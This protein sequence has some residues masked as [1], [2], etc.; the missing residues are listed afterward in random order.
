MLLIPFFGRAQQFKFQFNQTPVSSALVEVAGK[1]NNR[2]SFDA[3]NLEQFTVDGSLETDSIS[4]VFTWLLNGTGYRAELK[5]NT[6]LI[7][8][9]GENGV[10]SMPL[11]I[12]VSGYISDS[13]SGERLP[14]ATVLVGQK[15]AVIPSTVDGVFSVK[16]Q[17]NSAYFFQVRYLGYQTLDTV[18]TV[19]PENKVFNFA[20]QQKLQNIATIDVQGHKLEMLEVSNDAG[21]VTFNPRRFADLPNFGETDV[22]KTLQ[23]LPGISTQENSSQLNI[24]GS[25]ADQNLVTFDGFTLYNLDHFFGV[26]SALNPNVIKDI[27][28]Y[29]GGFDSRYG[30]RVSGIVE[31][32]GKSGDKTKPRVY[33]GVNLISANLTTEIPISEKL[34]LVAAGRRAYSDVYSSWLADAILAKQT[35][36]ASRFPDADEAIE[37]E[38][39]FSDF[40]T[41]LTWTPSKKDIVSFSA[42]GAK[43]NLNSSNVLEKDFIEIDTKDINK[44]GNYGFGISWKTQHKPNYVSELQLGHSGYYNDYYNNTTL[45]DSVDVQIPVNDRREYQATNEENKLIDYF[46]SYKST[47]FLNT[48]NQLEFGVASRY[49]TFNYYK[50]ADDDVVYSKLEKSAT[51]Y[52]GFIQDKIAVGEKWFVKPGFRINYYDEK[53][54]F[55]F[56]PRFAVHYMANENVLLKMAAGKYYQFLNKIAT[57]QTYGYNRDFW[58]LAEGDR[59]PVVSSEHL[60]L[61]TSITAGKFFFDVEG[62]YKNVSGLQEYLFSEPDRTPGET[63]SVEPGEEPLSLFIAGD[64][65]AYGIDF[66]AKYQITNFSSWLAY[67]LSKSTRNFDEINNGADVPALYD[68]RHEL[69]WTNMFSHKRWNFSGV[70]QYTT[71]SPY[72]ASTEKDSDFNVTREYKRLPDY[73]RVDLSANYNFNIKKVNIKPGA[74]LLNAFN[75]QNYLGVYVREFNFQGNSITE[76]TPI[77][78]QDITLNFFINFSF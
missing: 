39:Y 76:I 70:M 22:F 29:R 32:T 15:G 33:G 38:F 30:E 11:E 51:L 65:K 55:Y 20:L 58:V 46:L 13:E 12:R 44:W 10:E 50:D 8:K 4:D 69:K 23:L 73:F 61:G 72:I 62:Y 45:S 47:V 5:Y 56:E 42:Y 7:F 68:Q 26:F 57:E 43:D 37:P 34:S 19:T 2:I 66:L 24:R 63:P 71:G 6:W 77:K 49:T 78:A 48:A 3:D 9:I 74:S 53:D 41:K 31:I 67:S 54:K 64:G 75:T 52:T 60:I 28:V 18:I 59:N 17:Q 25:S 1:T 21:H 40:N 27:Q 35:G 36:R 14:Y 16:L